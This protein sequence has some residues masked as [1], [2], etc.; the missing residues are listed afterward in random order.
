M[1]DTQSTEV[2]VNDNEKDS[3]PNETKKSKNGLKH[4]LNLPKAQRT[5][6]TSSLV[7]AAFTS[8]FAWATYYYIQETDSGWEPL[9]ATTCN[10]YGF[11]L[12]LYCFFIFGYINVYILKPIVYPAYKSFHEPT[13]S[14]IKQSIK[15]RPKLVN[16]TRNA[17]KIF[18]IVFLVVI[19]IYLVVDTSDN[20]HRLVPLS[21]L[22]VFLLIGYI[23][24]NN[25]SEINWRTVIWGTILQFIFGLLTIRWEVGRN[26]LDCVGDKVNILLGY[27]FKAAEFPYGS[28]LVA[29]QQ[30]FAFKS[31]S[32]VFFISFLVNILY[33]YGI[34]QKV[35]GS[36]GAFLQWIMGTS[37]CE[38]VNSAANIFLGM[39]EAPLLLSPYL[40]NLTDSEIHSI[41]TSGFATVAGSVMAGYISYGARAQDLITA[42]IMSAPAA[43][44]FSKLMYPETE[45]VVM[46][47]EN[48]E[49]VEM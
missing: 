10:G 16:V 5:Y 32:T 30:V 9:R 19:V 6:L 21:G 3:V 34:M 23:V 12:I 47:K 35:V 41:M 38:S 24:S 18:Y 29:T 7:F 42:S 27:A 48:I 17:D 45:E 25:K 36:I 8:F 39:T 11:L 37:I 44:C 2:I 26:I 15:E 20:R 4:I 13:V 31:L 40:K 49:E 14:K 33:Y 43:L 22:I 46:H 1:N 28:N